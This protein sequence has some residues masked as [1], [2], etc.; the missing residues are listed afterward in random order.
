[1]EYGELYLAVYRQKKFEVIGPTL[2]FGLCAR[3]CEHTAEEEVHSY[4]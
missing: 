1:M 3:A 2:A 4:I